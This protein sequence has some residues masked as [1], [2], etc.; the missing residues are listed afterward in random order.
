MK[1]IK[2]KEMPDFSKP[3]ERAMEVGVSNLADYELLAIILGTG[4]RDLDVLD[5]S[6]KL[7]IEAGSLTSL[8]DL[9]ITELKE[10]SGIGNAKAISILSALELGR[11]AILTSS[12]QVKI[13][14]AKDIYYYASKLIGNEK[15]EILLAIFLDFKNNVI[16]KKIIS[17]GTLNSTA[18]Q[19]RDIIRWALKYSAYAIAICHNH[20]SGECIASVE[21]LRATDDI[22][23]SCQAVGIMFLDHLV[24]GKNSYYSICECKCFKV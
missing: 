21:D 15:Q 13:K 18:F 5:L 1:D 24:L 8:L 14:N 6:K 22:I 12:T 11:R 10:F 19:P 4:S 17:V 16:G 9:T 2:L 20:P 3:R 7:L 23:F